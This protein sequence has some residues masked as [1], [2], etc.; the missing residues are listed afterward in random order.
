MTPDFA[1]TCTCEFLHTCVQCLGHGWT[2]NVFGF[3]CRK[4]TDCRYPTGVGLY[5]FEVTGFRPHVGSL[6]GVTLFLGELYKPALLK[7]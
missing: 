4:T 1:N 6:Q 5:L 7:K 3:S 2:E